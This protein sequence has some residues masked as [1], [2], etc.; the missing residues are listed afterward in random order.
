MIVRILDEGQFELDEGAA[1]R[2]EQLDLDL[3]HA[4]ASHDQEWFEKA[5]AAI[6][7]EVRESGRPLGSG[8]IRPSDLFLPAPGS[9]VDEVKEL[10]ESE[11]VPE[12]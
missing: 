4:L 11:Q 9:S 12:A 3:S 7:A 5:L 10:L 8:S 6:L 1:T 2:L